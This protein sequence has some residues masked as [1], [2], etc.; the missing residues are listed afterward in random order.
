MRRV[1]VT[2]VAKRKAVSITYSEYVF[3]ALGMQYAVRMRHIFI[4]GLSGSTIFST[5]SHKRTN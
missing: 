2:I 1:R 5:L 4:G 3:V